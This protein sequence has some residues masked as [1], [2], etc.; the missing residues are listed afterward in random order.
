[1]R[2]GC[3]S[4]GRHFGGCYMACAVGRCKWQ[5][6]AVDGGWRGASKSMDGS[7]LKSPEVF[8]GSTTSRPAFRRISR[9]THDWPGHA[10]MRKQHSNGHDSGCLVNG[11]LLGHGGSH[12]AASIHVEDCFFVLY[13]Y[14]D[15]HGSGTHEP[16]PSGPRIASNQTP[17]HHPAPARSP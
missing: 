13:R 8:S 2:D 12:I 15:V 17:E 5:A 10:P 14:T 11:R 9:P 1:L 4:R 6:R 3:W 7:P 16:Q